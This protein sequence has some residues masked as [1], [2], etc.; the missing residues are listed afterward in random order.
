MMS[1][2]RKDYAKY[3][4]P[5]VLGLTRSHGRSHWIPGAW[6]NIPAEIVPTKKKD[7]LAA[8]LEGELSM[9]P[10]LEDILKHCLKAHTLEASFPRLRHFKPKPSKHV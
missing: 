9:F 10:T 6:R 8:I 7:H 5:F 1:D 3:I 2:I 4:T